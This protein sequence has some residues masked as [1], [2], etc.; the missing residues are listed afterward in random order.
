M[1]ITFDVSPGDD[2]PGHPAGLHRLRASFDP[3]PPEERRER[4]LAGFAALFGDAALNPIDY[5][6]HCWGTEQFAPGGPTA[7]VP[8][9][10]WTTYGPWLR[11]PVDGI[12]WAGHR[13]R[14]RVD[15]LPRRGRPVRP[16]RGRG[17][18]PGT[19]RASGDRL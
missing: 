8:P 12:H 15:R 13:D 2:G 1:F 18:R 11:K 4:A 6:D 16:A 14:R 17:G 9:G 5:I 19:V 7:A 10:S 3:L